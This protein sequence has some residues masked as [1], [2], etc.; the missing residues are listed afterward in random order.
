MQEVSSKSYSWTIGLTSATN[1]HSKTTSYQLNP[2]SFLAVPTPHCYTLTVLRPIVRAVQY[3]VAN[4]LG[5]LRVMAPDP[6]G[7]FMRGTFDLASSNRPV[8]I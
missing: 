1:D 5:L 6:L 8:N 7:K 2:F 3:I 4:A